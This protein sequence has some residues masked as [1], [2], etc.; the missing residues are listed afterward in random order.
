MDLKTLNAGCGCNSWGDVRV[1]IQT[2]SDLFYLKKTS[3][4]ILASLDHLP[5]KDQIFEETRC[6]HVLEHTPNPFDCIA[7]LK[8]VTKREILIHVPVW[9][10]WSFI[11]DSITLVKSFMLIPLI[12]LS[13]FKDH[14]YKVRNWRRRLGDH[15]YY[16]K[17]KKINR[18]Y[19]FFPLEY[20]IKIKGL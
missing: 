17:G 5:F 15:K 18:V 2:F 11:I 12:G 13:Y 7:E 16:I 20:E 9:H 8:R 14:L 4:N 10:L 3:A 19:F 1:D 6:H